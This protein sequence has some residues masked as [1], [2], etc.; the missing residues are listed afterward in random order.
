LNAFFNTSDAAVQQ[1]AW[2]ESQ[3][4]METAGGTSR[5]KAAINLV[6][7]ASHTQEAENS[8]W[9]KDMNNTIAL[10]DALD[11]SGA[12]A[13]LRYVKASIGIEDD[14]PE[15]IEW[16]REAIPYLK[17][18]EYFGEDWSHMLTNARAIL[19]RAEMVQNGLRFES[20]EPESSD[21]D[22]ELNATRDVLLASQ[23]AAK[24]ESLTTLRESEEGLEDIAW[25]AVVIGHPNRFEDVGEASRYAHQLAKKLIERG[26][27]PAAALPFAPAM[28]VGLLWFLWSSQKLT[29]LEPELAQGQANTLAE[30]IKDIVT[31]WSPPDNEPWYS[32]IQNFPKRIDKVLSYIENPPRK[33]VHGEIK[34]KKEDLIREAQEVLSQV[35]KDYSEALPACAAFVTGIL[36]VKNTYSPLQGSAPEA[37]HKK[38]IDAVQLLN[39]DNEGRFYPYLMRGFETVRNRE[40][41]ELE[42]WRSEQQ[43]N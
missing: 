36:A 2:Q 30:L 8:S 26:N 3:Y 25:N 21:T 32:L 42:R 9:L 38:L 6:Q 20:I 23:Q 41:N 13:L 34:A 31:H 27:I 33:R 10:A 14:E 4:H 16:L 17:A 1:K 15:A 18:Q 40:P 35:H 24:E 43:S 39:A 7:S 29:Y 22:E 12:Q 28:L 19:G 11:H 5:L 37:I